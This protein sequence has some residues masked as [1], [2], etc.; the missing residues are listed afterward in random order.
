MCFVEN[1]SGTTWLYLS[2]PWF[3]PRYD[4]SKRGEMFLDVTS[5][6][7]NLQSFSSRPKWPGLTSSTWNFT[8]FLTVE[9]VT[10]KLR[11]TQT[12]KVD[13]E[14]SSTKC[15]CSTDPSHWCTPT[16]PPTSVRVRNGS[17]TLNGFSTTQRNKRSRLMSRTQKLFT[18]IGYLWEISGNCYIRRIEGGKNYTVAKITTNCLYVTTFLVKKGPRLVQKANCY[19]TDFI[20]MSLT[21]YMRYISFK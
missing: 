1:Y 16:G 17:L 9:D 5:L 4:L 10:D 21:L 2:W 13:T 3:K 14:S 7:L 12:S 18:R 20:F 11:D 19:V 6:G 8:V 15:L